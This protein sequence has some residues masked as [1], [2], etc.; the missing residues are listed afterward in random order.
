LIRP[1]AVVILIFMTRSFS[2]PVQSGY[3]QKVELY[4]ETGHTGGF[5]IAFSPDCKTVASGGDDGTVK[6]WDV[7]SGEELCSMTDDTPPSES[8]GVRSLAFAL[9]GRTIASAHSYSIRLWDV[10][11]R[12]QL[13]TLTTLQNDPLYLI[14]FSPNGKTIASGG[15]GAPINLWDVSS[16]RQLMLRG[17]TTSTNSIAFSP[18]GTLVAAGGNENTIRVWNVSSGDQLYILRGHVAWVVSLAYSPDGKTIASGSL[19][20]IYKLWDATSGKELHTLSAPNVTVET[21]LYLPS[22]AFSPDSKTIVT[23]NKDNS[24]RLWDVATAREVYVL[25]GQQRPTINVSFFSQWEAGCVRRPIEEARPSQ[26][27]KAIVPGWYCSSGSWPIQA[28]VEA[29]RT[30]VRRNSRNNNRPCLTSPG[31]NV[32]YHW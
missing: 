3:E 2:A 29:V 21:G 30:L 9:N 8:Y 18:D 14:A 4:V 11:S 1:I 10:A 25:R 17:D 27:H 5:T 31:V 16:G 28:F 23:G 15:V 32:R 7:A 22:V 24:T 6:L 13:R 20:N 12:R 19:D 26:R